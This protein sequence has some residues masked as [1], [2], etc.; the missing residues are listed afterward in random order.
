ME[1]VKALDHPRLLT[2]PREIRDIV[3]SYLSRKSECYDVRIAPSWCMKFRLENA[4]YP[5][6][7]QVC[8]RIY[9]EYREAE[10]FEKTAATLLLYYNSIASKGSWKKIASALGVVKQITINARLPPYWMPWSMLETYLRANMPLLRTIRFIE[11]KT[12]GGLSTDSQ[13]LSSVHWSSNSVSRNTFTKVF[14]DLP[15]VQETLAKHVEC[16]NPNLEPDSL[17]LWR[18]SSLAIHHPRHVRLT[19]YTIE[20]PK[21]LAWTKDLFFEYWEPVDYPQRVLDLLTPERR[22]AI[23]KLPHTL[24]DW[25]ESHFSPSA[26]TRNDDSSRG[27]AKV[28]T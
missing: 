27:Q 21:K 28:L 13:L 9:Q 6:V 20:D 12:I 7:S 16:K 26:E 3:Y 19:L 15:L 18:I 4:P 10:C 24:S 5:R 2:L 11:T 17:P 14:L 25:T 23:I 8:T 22:E 1:F